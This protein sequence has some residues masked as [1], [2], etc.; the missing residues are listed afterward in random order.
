VINDVFALSP[1]QTEFLLSFSL[2]ANA[3]SALFMGNLGDKYGKKHIILASTLI[4]IVGSLLSAIGTS[5]I[6]VLLGRIL[7]GVG[8][9]GPLVLGPL[10]ILD[11]YQGQEQQHKMN[12]LNGVCTLGISFAPLIGSYATMLFGW[13]SNFTLLVVFGVVSLMLCY[14]FLP[15]DKQNNAKVS[16]SV[17]E[18]F[19][20]FQ[21]KI[22]C[23]YLICV[24][25]SVA[26]YYVFVGMGSIVY[27]DSLGV[28]LKSF[29]L[30]QGAMAFVFG[31]LSIL[32]G[33]IVRKIGN[34]VAFFGSLA[35][36]SV[37]YVLIF[38]AI[39]FNI[40][41]PLLITIIMLISTV[42]Y[43]IPLNLLYVLALSVLPNGGGK[44]SAMMQ[45]G[46]WVFT[47]LGV[48]LASYFY[49]HDFRS[50]GTLVATM[51]CIAFIF[52]M[53]LLKKDKRLGAELCKA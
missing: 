43:V 18:Y 5:F 32:S 6:V 11:L 37:F 36:V 19:S 17:T 51:D 27:V 42:G 53:V 21:S 22:A 30:Y 26:A 10:I 50:T 16:L 2:L 9:A 44:M 20:V 45:I 4:F 52:I 7:Q 12:I 23:L 25:L 38:F 1:F 41:D 39:L 40:K 28:S 47:I 49:S 8:A 48:Q 46:K 14:Y 31:I 35:I 24:S 34:R 3:I 15:Q 29:G 33:R 13:R